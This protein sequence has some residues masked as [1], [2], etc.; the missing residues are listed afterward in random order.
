MISLGEA[1]PYYDQRY[2][3]SKSQLTPLAEEEIR[4]AEG[5]IV[6]IGGPTKRGFRL[7]RDSAILPSRP[8]I[9]NRPGYLGADPSSID[10]LV[11]GKA[12]PFD[13]ASIGMFLASHISPIDNF[14]K[15]ADIDSEDEEVRDKFDR[16]AYEEYELCL[17]DPAYKP[18]SNL[19]IGMLQEMTRTLRPSGLI[20]LE[21]IGQNDIRI[22]SALGHATFLQVFVPGKDDLYDCIFKSST[23]HQ[24]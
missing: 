19:R 20:L 10:R 24:E 4:N 18:A 7:L 13:D 23:Q 6:E 22:A 11:D 1:Y 12:M 21:A 8:L 14:K 9:T 16:R 3:Q 17:A 2:H 15:N 5:P